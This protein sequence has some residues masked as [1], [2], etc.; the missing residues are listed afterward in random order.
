[1]VSSF[2]FRFVVAAVSLVLFAAAG[3][4]ASAQN[5][6]LNVTATVEASCTLQGGTL[7][8]GTYNTT[9][10]GPTDSSANITYTCSEGTIITVSLDDGD[11]AVGP[12]SRAMAG[13]GGASLGYGLYKEDSRTNSWGTGPVDGLTPPATPPGQQTLTV[14]GRIPPG[15][16]A[17]PGAYSDVVQITLNI[18]P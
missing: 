6:N 16:S 15:Q 9:A 8:F 14:Y 5:A 12:G 1:V 10:D 11:H 13:P 7:A 3:Q 4:P 17:A 18:N 2:Y